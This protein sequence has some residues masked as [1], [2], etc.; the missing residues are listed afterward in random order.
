MSAHGPVDVALSVDA[1]SRGGAERVLVT[2]ANDLDRRRFRVHFIATREP[3]P[4]AVDLAPHVTVHSLDR[5]TRWDV[6]VVRRFADVV[7][8]H[9]I[10]LVHTHSHSASYLA[11]LAR[12]AFGGQWL[13]VVHDHHPLVEG[14][15][16]LRVADR[17][18]LSG[19]DHYFAVSDPLAEYAGRWVGIPDAR[20]EKLLNGVATPDVS[21]AG[22]APVFTI[23]QVARIMP[24]KD[25]R[26]ALA[27]AARLREHLPSFRWL[28]I[29]RTTS[30]YA[31]ECQAEAA[32]L[33]LGEHVAFM[34]ELDDVAMLVRQAHVGV[35]TSRD[36]GLPI[37]LLEYMA[38]SLPVVVTDVG[39]CGVPVR[40]SGGGS[41][42][43]S[44]D[45]EAFMRALLAVA[46]DAAAAER[47][48]AAN[49]RYVRRLY[50]TDAMVAR[51][52]EVYDALLGDRQGRGA[53]G[54][55][56]ALPSLDAHRSGMAR[57][58]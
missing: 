12:L 8:R 31:R 32:R 9:D 1:L 44:G 40:A 57:I 15:L 6:G 28:L 42:V 43:A 2:L 38:A 54:Q 21:G 24:Q 13:H 22:K 16:V 4:L 53:A 58:R 14:S 17:L 37:A 27:V 10:R 39:D 34:G 48:G 29:G 55:P 11:R 45:V 25:H 33:G 46:A 26:M 47:A 3:G 49:R 50:G 51:V 52:A 36:E 20:C 30:D 7:R 5:R 19:V 35:L 18:L 41:V 56:G 23:V